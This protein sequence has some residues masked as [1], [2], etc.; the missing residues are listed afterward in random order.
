MKR[1]NDLVS[2]ELHGDAFFQVGVHMSIR[3]CIMWIP[4]TSIHLHYM[5]MYS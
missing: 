2:L 1:A 5:E 3:V 4:L